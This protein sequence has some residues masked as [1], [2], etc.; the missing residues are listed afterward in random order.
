[1]DTPEKL[2]ELAES[3][4][5]KAQAAGADE[6]TVAVSRGS[7]VSIE[8]R[9]GK[10]E[11]ATE[12][13]TR[14]LVL[15]VL[16]DDRFSSNSTSDLRPEALEAFIARSVASTRYLEPDPARRLPDAELCGRGVSEETL[17]QDDPAW[18]SRTAEE[19][20]EQAEAIERLLL[21]LPRTD[22]ISCSSYV[23]DG[24]AESVR[25][26][27][28]GFQGIE[29]GAWFA[30]GGDMTLEEGDRRPESGAWY[31]ARHLADLPRVEFI[32]EEI[33]RRVAERLGSQAA[34]S[35]TYP[36]VLANRSAGKVLGVLGG[37]MAGGSLH[38]HRSCLEG[39]LGERIGSELFTLVDDPT[40]P[41]GLGSRPWDGDAL[42]ARPRTLIE[43]G[44][45][46]QYNIGVY[47]GRK[48]GMEPTS[49]GRSN[50]VVP[51]GDVPLAELLKAYPKAILV[52]GFL[53]G[54][55]NGATGDFSFGIRGT[56]L[57]NGEPAGALSEMNV[58]GNVTD[59][60]QRLVAVGDDPWE[61]SSVRS[62]TL[63]FDDVQF[64]GT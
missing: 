4:M 49:G 27:S 7:Q 22:R 8:R 42:V 57:E 60:F 54:N 2:L 62:P 33:E 9:G 47:Y 20:A 41:R 55:S 48:L 36:M 12:S 25:V 5:K 40:I 11:Q 10:V 45:L 16:S 56:L 63:I 59:I 31:A 43:K 26:M 23:G 3:V 1:M 46:K 17:D 14:G 32:A 50:W 53:G 51:P 38:E 13:T 58:T 15:S 34:P 35:G 44:V 21:E 18:A 37:P 28:N 24:R 30:A 52:T 6:V 29:A 61:W 39:K 19:R 64:S